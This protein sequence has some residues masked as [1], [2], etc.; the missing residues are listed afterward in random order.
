MLW[1]EGPP[2]LGTQTQV[3]HWSLTSCLKLIGGP[4]PKLWALKVPGKKFRAELGTFVEVMITFS[5]NW[6]QSHLKSFSG[7]PFGVSELKTHG[8]VP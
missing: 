7:A 3:T 2:N 8:S 4:W 1:R 5:G 6:S